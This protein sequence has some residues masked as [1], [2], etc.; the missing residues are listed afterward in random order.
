MDKIYILKLCIF[1]N[2]LFICILFFSFFIFNNN[3]SNHYF[4]IGWSKHF[5]FV[6]VTIDSPIKYF[7]LCTFITILNI[8]EVF[9]NDIAGP[10]IAFSTYNPYKNT[11]HDFSRFELE[12]YSNIIYFIQTIK[13]YFKVL[14]TL[15]QIDIAAISFFSSQFAA[16][17]TIRFLLDYKTFYTTNNINN[18]EY[19]EINSI[20][21]PNSYLTI[22]EIQNQYQNQYQNIM[23]NI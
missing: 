8:S 20:S 16:F 5:V 22:S 9:L 10:I 7:G 15:S 21:N 1:V 4:N 2:L 12:L 14:T 17:L 18:N 11:I 6:S 13:L 23:Y 3:I 19:L